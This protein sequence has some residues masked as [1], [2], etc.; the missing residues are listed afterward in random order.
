MA[1]LGNEVVLFG[2]RDDNDLDDTWTFDWASWTPGLPVQFPV[3]ARRRYD[4]SAS[5]APQELRER[6]QRDNTM[7]SKP[8]GLVQQGA[9]GSVSVMDR[10]SMIA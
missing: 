2:G 6:S 5:V 3:R 8:V 9:A 7:L 10:V 1:T 4:R